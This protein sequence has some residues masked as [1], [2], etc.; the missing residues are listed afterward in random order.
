MSDLS[1]DP[2]TLAQQLATYDIQALQSLLTRRTNTLKA[3]TAALTALRSAMSDFRTTLTNLNKIGDGMLKNQATTSLEGIATVTVSSAAQKG[4]YDLFV[5]QLASSHQIAFNDMTDESIQSATGT[6]TLSVNGKSLDVEMDDLKS[7]SDLVQKINNYTDADAPKVTASLIR[8]DGKVTLMLSSDQSGALNKVTVDT[9]QMD[10]TSAAKFNSP[11]T[12]SKAQNAIYRLGGENG[13][14]FESASN[15]LDGLIDGVTIELTKAQKSGDDPLRIN[16]NIDTETTKEQ[17]QK[18][19]DAYNTLRTALSKLTASGSSSEE[20]GAFAGDAGIASLKGSINAMLRQTFGEKNM[21]EYGI[22]ASRD[23]TLSIDSSTL[24]KALKEDPQGLSGLFNGD[25]G[26]LKSLDKTLDKYLNSSTGLLK[27]RKDTLDR[28][29]TEID[30]KTDKIQAR[31]DTSYQRYL[32]QF[33]Q[34]QAAM[35]KMN[36]ATS[37]F[38]LV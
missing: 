20:R 27:G 35:A 8:T 38:D 5:E 12:I 22:T 34:L 24:E 2:Q 31:Y 7:M 23:G 26:M 19:I 28:Q 10:T 9:S 14:Q 25:Q 4:S 13:K 1:I 17:I 11:D 30:N 3:Q 37:M 33:T 16:V 36:S 6:M 18:F 21:T 15:K 32:K 29:Q